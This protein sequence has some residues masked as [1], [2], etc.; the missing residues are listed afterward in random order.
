MICAGRFDCFDAVMHKNK[1]DHR[2]IEIAKEV[3]SR[4]CALTSTVP[5]RI[6]Q[7]SSTSPVKKLKSVACLKV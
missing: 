1:D 5:N 2:E 7:S 6:P 4:F 3:N